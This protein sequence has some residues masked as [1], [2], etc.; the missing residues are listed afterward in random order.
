MQSND[1]IARH[2]ERLGRDATEDDKVG[3]I[4]CDV[5]ELKALNDT[6]GHARGDDVLVAV[7]RALESAVRRYDVVARLS[8]DEFVIL[9]DRV[10]DLET[11]DLVA[12]KCREA[13]A[14]ILRP[15]GRTRVSISV[16]GILAGPDDDAKGLID[17]AD[18]EMMVDKQRGRLERGVLPR[19][20]PWAAPEEPAAD[21]GDARE[22]DA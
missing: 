7:A 13:V 8:G 3:L 1:L 22:P 11:L 17:R 4:F 19:G 9:L 18:A 15:D 2:E 5:D 16:G 12:G 20:T 21:G 6:W 10:S 14:T